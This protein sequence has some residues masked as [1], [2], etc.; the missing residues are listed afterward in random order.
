MLELLLFEFALLL[1]RELLLLELFRLLLLLALGGL[2]RGELSGL[3]RGELLRLQLLLPALLLELRLA[4]GRG[5]LL[6]PLL[7]Q[8]DIR[9]L[10]LHGRR[11]RRD[12]HG[13]RRRRLRRRRVRHRRP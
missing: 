4:G 6:A 3:L 2:L 10:V 5:L 1:F 11:G 9:F 12:F 7:L 8:G 13:R